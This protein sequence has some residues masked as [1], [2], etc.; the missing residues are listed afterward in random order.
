MVTAF[1]GQGHEVKLMQGT[2]QAIDT[3]ILDLDNTIYDWFAV[4]YASFDPIYQ[5]LIKITGLPADAI[6][7]DIRIVHQARRT[8]EYTFLLEEIDALKDLRETGD[9]RTRFHEAISQR[10][11]K[12]V[13]FEEKRHQDY[14][15][16]GV[17]A[18]L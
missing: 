5:E 4:W 8:S 6:E 12:L 14:R 11:P 16:Y 3:L 15:L 7:A 1:L 17:D 13:G 9:I 18:L 10:V 2:R